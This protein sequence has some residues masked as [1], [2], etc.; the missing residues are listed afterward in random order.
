MSCSNIS[1]N[2]L[3][4][5][6]CLNLKI[7]LPHDHMIRDLSKS[8]KPIICPKLLAIECGYC[9]K[10]GHTVS[11]CPVLKA[12]KQ[13]HSNVKPNVEVSSNTK[14]NHVIDSDGFTHISH[15]SSKT[16]IFNIS[17][18]QKVE[19]LN[20]YFGALDVE[21]YDSDS[22][23]CSQK[24]LSSDTSTFNQFS[25]SIP[26]VISK[27]NNIQAL[28]DKLGIQFTFCWEMILMM[29]SY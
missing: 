9:H 3:S 25:N 28:K 29:N 8:N 22:E 7:P 24:I 27:T 21:D 2:T 26:P 13:S 14:R 6:F 11:Y 4:C 5:S 18:I 1:A 15:R 12:N 20:S 19:V 10:K 23:T 16:K 17:K